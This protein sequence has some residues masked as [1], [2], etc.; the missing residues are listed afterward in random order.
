[1]I[2]FLDPNN[3]LNEH[4]NSLTITY[5]RTVNIIFGHYPYLENI[6]NLII[7]IK[8]NINKDMTNY[9]N[10][11]GNMTSW[12]HFIKDPIFNHFLSY[13]INKNQISQPDL[14]K[15]FFSKNTIKDAWGN[16]IK[17]RDK[18]NYHEHN[19]YH[20]VLYLTKGCDLIVPELNIK[21]TP[22]PGDYY[23]FPMGIL[24]GFEEYTEEHNRY[25]LIFNIEKTKGFEYSK[26]M[27]DLNER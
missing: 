18:L 11:K 17:K 5:P 21:I 19:Y 14:F 4:K 23:I 2:S 22:N 9:T 7:N 13:I 10:V 8:N 12:D 24:H 3:K 27:K 20:G 25:S 26:S 1:M 15:H 16:E 6:H